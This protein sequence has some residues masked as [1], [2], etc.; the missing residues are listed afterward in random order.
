MIESIH[1]QHQERYC[2]ISSPSVDI[3]FDIEPNDNIYKRNLFYCS[4]LMSELISL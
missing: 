3:V 4:R 1:G 2:V